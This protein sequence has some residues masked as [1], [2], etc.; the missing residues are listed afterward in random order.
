MPRRH[1]S[2]LHERFRSSAPCERKRRF[3]SEREALDAVA[4]AILDFSKPELKV[5]RCP[6]CGYWHLSSLRKHDESA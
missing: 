6:F 5:Y 4:E 3:G 2:P 1:R